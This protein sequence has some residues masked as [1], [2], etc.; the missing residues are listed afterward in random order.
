MD[1][2]IRRFAVATFLLFLQGGVAQAQ[3]PLVVPKYVRT[4]FVEVYRDPFGGKHIRT[5]YAEIHKPGN[6]VPRGYFGPPVVVV[7]DGGPYEHGAMRVE[8]QPSGAMRA[9]KPTMAAD[10]SQM[11]WNML[12]ATIHDANARLSSDLTR[13][14]SGE[15]WR[16]SLKLDEI[17][18]LVPSPGAGSNRTVGA[19]GLAGPPMESARRELQEIAKTLD[20]LSAEPQGNGVV[21]LASFRTL[22]GALAEYV[23]PADMRTQRQLFAASAELAGSLEQ[24]STANTWLKYFA[25]MPGGVLSPYQRSERKMQGSPDLI[26]LLERFE[27]VSQDARYSM[28]AA[29]PAFQRTHGL[30]L[31]YISEHPQRENPKSVDPTSEELPAPLP[32]EI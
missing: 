7:P 27:S 31:E 10:F 17:A 9:G 30:L 24:F 13:V 8:P 6:R 5:P 12:L 20:S 14:S 25:L 28:I 2:S 26:T 19:A 11:D 3:R 21:S 22:R 16:T 1:V 4:P 23:L 15:F 18:R 32:A 29:L